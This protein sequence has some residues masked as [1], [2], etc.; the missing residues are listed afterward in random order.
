M[1]E[2]PLIGRCA[3]GNVQFDVSGAAVPGSNIIAAELAARCADCGVMFRWLGVL[4]TTPNDGRPS[5]SADGEW[6]RLPMVAAGETPRRLA[7]S[8]DAG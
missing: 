7:V 2:Q 4:R 6:L 5:L 3:H 8:N 1:T